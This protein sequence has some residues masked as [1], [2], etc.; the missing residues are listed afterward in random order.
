MN[1]NMAAAS[2]G[3]VTTLSAT[4]VYA[5]EFGEDITIS[6]VGQGQDLPDVPDRNNNIRLSIETIVMSALIFIAI[7]AWFEFLRS[8]FD[9]IFNSTGTHNY[10][11]ILNRLWYAIFITTVSLIGVYVTYRVTNPTARVVDLSI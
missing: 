4:G 5:D 11:A 7:L 6:T 9:N 8:W 1:I 3:I 2:A 10:Y